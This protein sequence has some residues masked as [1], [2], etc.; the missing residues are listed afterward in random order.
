M[1]AIGYDQ[2]ILKENLERN[3]DKLGYE[4]ELKVMEAF[5]PNKYHSSK[6]K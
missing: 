2:N 5:E 4:P 1:I 3:K 6:M